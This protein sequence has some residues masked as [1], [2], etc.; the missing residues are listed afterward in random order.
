MLA[1]DGPEVSD[2][3]ADISPDV[4]RNLVGD[5]QSAIVYGFLRSGNSVMNESAHLARFLLFDV[6][7]GV[8]VLNFA[9]EADRKLFR[10]KFSDVIR[11]TLTFNQRGPGAFD[12]VGYRSNQAEARNNDATIQIQSSFW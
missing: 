12:R 9:G 4:F 5:F 1:L 7:Q 8:E 11:A 2:A 3:T 6:I 10:V